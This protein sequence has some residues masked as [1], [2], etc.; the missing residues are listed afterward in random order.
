MINL[1]P[2]L[3]H[4]DVA[5]LVLEHA[6]AHASN[7]VE[8]L[9]ILRTLPVAE[10]PD[11]RK[12]VLVRGFVSPALA[13]TLGHAHLL[14]DFPKWLLLGAHLEIIQ[15]LAATGDV[16]ALSQFY[17]NHVGP[18]AGPGPMA[19]RKLNEHQ[20][21]QACISSGHIP[22]L[23]WLATT[24]KRER[25]VPTCITIGTWAAPLRAS[26]IPFLDWSLR[27][28]YF[29]P[30]LYSLGLEAAAEAGQVCVF[31]WLYPHHQRLGK[32][33]EDWDTK[34]TTRAATR[35]GQTSVLE[36]WWTHVAPNLPTPKRFGKIVDIALASGNLDVVLWWWA[37]FEAHGT[38]DY[39][40]GTRRAANCA[41]DSGSLPVLEWLWSVAARSDAA[42][43]L[44]D[45][46]SGPVP[47]GACARSL[48]LIQWWQATTQPSPS[49]PVRWTPHESSESARVGAVDVLDWVLSLPDQSA[50]DWGFGLAVTALL[51]RQQRVL[52]WYLARRAH[53]P[54]HQHP[55]VFFDSEMG[56]THG[57]EVFDWWETHLGFADASFTRLGAEIAQHCGPEWVAWWCAQLAQPK[58]RGLARIAVTQAL[59]LAQSAWARDAL[60]AAA[61]GLGYSLEILMFDH[62]CM[63]KAR[64][65]EAVCWWMVALRGDAASGEWE[66]RPSA[67]GDVCLGC[68]HLRQ[69]LIM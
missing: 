37:K 63:R 66:A 32:T 4:G 33:F 11:T 69:D 68:E 67:G 2:T 44:V 65:V 26:N 36:W 21:T 53:L 40:F 1:G 23:E 16:S 5:A 58:R 51:Y 25:W 14:K 18:F 57:L 8:A 59:L 54:D 62:S 64:T 30:I 61:A 45:W 38:P 56:Y 27:K 13:V 24:A 10:Q 29:D 3:H 20:L 17:A 52:D 47:I 39:R 6:A 22:V 19:L 35:G 12:T 46:N 41:I 31:E 7:L 50:V 9:A 55:Q 28:G 48:H 49:A 15:A 34:M 60:A 42:K 43:I